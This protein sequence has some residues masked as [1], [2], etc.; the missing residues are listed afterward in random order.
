MNYADMSS[1][2]L[3]TACGDSGERWAEAFMQVVAKMV[4]HLPLAVDVDLM[5]GWFANAIEE[6]SR[7][8][9]AKRSAEVMRLAAER[10]EALLNK[11]CSFCGK[12]R[13]ACAKL[14]SGPG[15]TICDECVGLAADITAYE[16]QLPVHNACPCLHTTPC[17]DRCTCLHML[18]S[19][20]C[21][22]CCSYGS[23]E[24]QRSRAERLAAVIDP[25][26]KAE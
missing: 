7:T 18:S 11:G 14:V 15:V 13:M 24:Q 1:A 22:R 12:A 8:R 25:T 21:R 3:L 10:E 6:A 19:S 2:E 20:G 17:H 16:S 26:N 4:P 9:N 5:R 23:P